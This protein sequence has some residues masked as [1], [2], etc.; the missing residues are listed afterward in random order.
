MDSLFK[1][2]S[3]SITVLFAY[4]FLHLFFFSASFVELLGLDSTI[5]SIVLVR[6][7]SMFIL[8]LAVLMFSVRN[9]PT[10]KARLYICIA[11]EVTL[12]GIACVGIYDL[13]KGNVNF[14]ILIAIITELMFFILFGIITIRDW[15]IEKNNKKGSTQHRV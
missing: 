6:R 11:L 2:V 10:S 15:K 8:G 3:I 7:T 14:L 5:S 9:L 12:S 1:I 13:I 4:L